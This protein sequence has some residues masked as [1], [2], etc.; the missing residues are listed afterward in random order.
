MKREIQLLVTDLDN[1]LY[2]WVTY[3]SMSFY[4]MVDAAVERFDF[5]REQLL[6]EL[7]EIH[8]QYHNSEQP[9]A[10]LETPLARA[11]F[12]GRSR[13]ELFHV[14]DDAFHAFNSARNRTLKTYPGVL[15]TL[16]A[17][18]AAGCSV[19]AHTEATATNAHFRLKKL[20]LAS[21]FDRLYAVRPAGPAHPS[22]RDTRDAGTALPIETLGQHQRKPN[23]EVLS[24][25]CGDF[26]VPPERTLYVG[27]SLT[28]DVGMAVEAGVLC[29]WAKYG[30]TYDR[31]LWSGLVRVT[32][33]TDEDVR[34][35]EEAKK[36]FGGV[37]PDLTLAERMDEI[38]G[39]FEFSTSEPQSANC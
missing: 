30:T 29:A 21:Y 33:W 3:F 31:S 11:A 14:M 35:A 39:A 23:P 12:P 9:F 8:R 18:T 13:R 7:R 10:L 6:D 19:A 36:R 26:G 20:D 2:D 16:Q 25:I 28:N 1:T 5:P 22:P 38:L 27:D 24:R 32:H 34:D 15:E 37:E 4:A 17:A